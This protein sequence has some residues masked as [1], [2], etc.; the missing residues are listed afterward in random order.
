MDSSVSDRSS[1]EKI[2]PAYAGGKDR[3]EKPGKPRP[4]DIIHKNIRAESFVDRGL[5]RPFEAEKFDIL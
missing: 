1:S 4:P 2:Y 5:L 3:R